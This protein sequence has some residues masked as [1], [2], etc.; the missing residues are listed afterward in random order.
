M[1]WFWIALATLAAVGLWFVLAA[2]QGG[3]TAAGSRDGADQTKTA[4]PRDDRDTATDLAR[5]NGASTSADSGTRAAQDAPAA[6]PAASSAAGMASGSGPA[7]PSTSNA[8]VAADSS[9]ASSRTA[10]TKSASTGSSGTSTAT[11]STATTGATGSTSAATATNPATGSPST[12]SSTI[13]AASAVPTAAPPAKPAVTTDRRN[14][15]DIVRRIDDR[16][17]ELDGRYRVTGNGREDDPYR[18]S[19]EILTS[20]GGYIDPAQYAVL[21]PPWLRL[22]DGTNVEISGYYSTPVRVQ[23]TQ[24]LLLTLNRWDGCCVGLPPTPFDA[25]DASLKTPLDMKGLHLVRFGTF[26]GRLRVEVLEAAG[27]LLGLYRLEDATFEAK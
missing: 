9:T 18:I 12:P 1:R 17:I 26:R 6:T 23:Q 5:S 24:Q 10:G 4:S 25:I 8:G 14:P 2:P 13:P 15:N 27:Y 22:L 19:W 21:P 11:T 7:D 3:I 20:A 16:T